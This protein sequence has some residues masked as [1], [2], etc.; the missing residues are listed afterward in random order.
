MT[1]YST[2]SLLIKSTPKDEVWKENERTGHIPSHLAGCR[3]D[4]AAA[5]PG[6]GPEVL[7]P[8]LPWLRGCRR[9]GR[10]WS[11]TPPTEAAGCRYD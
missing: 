6:E 3:P 8:L 7:A 9:W 11:R 2:S 5:P 4:L 10:E 1:K